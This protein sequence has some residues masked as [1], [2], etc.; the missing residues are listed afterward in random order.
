MSEFADLKMGSPVDAAISDKSAQKSFPASPRTRPAAPPP[1]QPSSLRST[2]S[3]CT[4][5]APHHLPRNPANSGLSQII[6]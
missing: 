2:R 6:G 4:R 5:Q 3:R 1:P